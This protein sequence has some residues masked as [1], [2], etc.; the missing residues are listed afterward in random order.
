MYIREMNGFHPGVLYR[1][2]VGG[3]PW[4]KLMDSEIN[5]QDM[6]SIIDIIWPVAVTESLNKKIPAPQLSKIL[7]EPLAS[8]TDIAK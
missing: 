8:C 1:S 3:H 7:P 4:Y 2:L 6:Q 5:I